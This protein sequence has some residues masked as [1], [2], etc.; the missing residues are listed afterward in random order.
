MVSEARRVFNHQLKLSSYQNPLL[1]LHTEHDHLVEISHA[2]R[3]YEWSA[4]PQKTM[5]RFPVGDHNSIM[6]WTKPD[7]VKALRD[8][9]NLVEVPST[10][11]H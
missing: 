5:I 3:N 4:S 11:Q 7:Y 8:F 6:E 9:V 10:P 2:E 1:I